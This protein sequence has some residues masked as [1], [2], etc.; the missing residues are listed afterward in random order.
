MALKFDNES[1]SA[2]SHR[3]S[4]RVVDLEN[5]VSYFEAVQRELISSAPLKSTTNTRGGRR[6]KAD[7]EADREA[8]LEAVIDSMKRVIER[9]QRENGVLRKSGTSNQK[10]VEVGRENRSLK[11]KLEELN[12]ALADCK[13]K[14]VAQTDA[15]RRAATAREG[16]S[17]ARRELKK[18][19]SALSETR[20]QASSL[21]KEVNDAHARA[22]KAEEALSRVRR[23]A[24]DAMVKLREK[25]SSLDSEGKRRESKLA[26]ASSDLEESQQYCEELRARLGRI[27]AEG[28]PATADA[29]NLAAHNKALEEQVGQLRAMVRAGKQRAAGHGGA[30]GEFS[31]DDVVELYER[32]SGERDKLATEVAQLRAELSAFDPAFFE[33][34][35]DLKFTSAQVAQQRDFYEATSRE[36]SERLGIDHRLADA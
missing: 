25:C 12:A 31:Y 17:Q 10:Y 7:R 28:G 15:T 29:G 1:A 20:T 14:E 21:Q 4:A 26:Q 11:N 2:K 30:A 27:A 22:Q 13:K 8:E 34:L 33:E 18:D 23:G 6:P 19:R 35:E 16:L 3:L 24:E 32:T 9:L 36:L 5:K